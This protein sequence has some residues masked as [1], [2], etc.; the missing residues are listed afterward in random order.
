MKDL[1]GHLAN[2]V[3]ICD[4]IKFNGVSEDAIKFRLFLFSLRNNAKVWLNSHAPNT[5]TTWADLSKAFLNKYFSPRRTAKLRMEIS[6]F[7]Q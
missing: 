4:T 7:G 6:S 3:E 1:N 2:F 5:F